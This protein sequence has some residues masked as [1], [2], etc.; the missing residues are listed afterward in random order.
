MDKKTGR[1]DVFGKS[2]Y[3]GDL[4]QSEYEYQVIVYEDTEGDFSGHL[5]CKPGHPCENIPYS[6]EGKYVKIF[7]REN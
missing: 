4:L 3:V 7:E 1:V 2:I 5:V 6:L